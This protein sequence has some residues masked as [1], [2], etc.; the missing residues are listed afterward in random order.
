MSEQF[1]SRKISPSRPIIKILSFLASI[2]SLLP[3]S[4]CSTRKGIV[5]LQVYS[6]AGE[7]GEM[8]NAELAITENQREVGLM[9]RKE[10]ANNK[11]MLFVYP[12]EGVRDFWMKNTYLELDMIF[13]NK[14]FSV[15]HILKHVPPLN[16]EKRSSIKPAQYVL[17][18]RGGEAERLG[19]VEGSR[20]VPMEVLK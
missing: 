8:I 14:D 16:E 11:G 4:A 20:I 18:L 19:I 12:N 7:K 6:P 15:V 3:F 1:L 9:Y 5:D 17:E 10:L 13:C 2:L